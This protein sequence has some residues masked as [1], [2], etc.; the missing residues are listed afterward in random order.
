MFGGFFV[1]WTGVEKFRPVVFLVRLPPDWVS[2]VV[3]SQA[4]TAT[5][6]KV[7][8]R[9]FRGFRGRGPP[10]LGPGHPGIA[11]NSKPLARFVPF[12]CDR[13]QVNKTIFVHGPL[14]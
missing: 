9:V 11:N 7:F 5:Q 13:T 12:V 2:V 1:F 4:K 8:V 10:R 6:G 3:R 14:D